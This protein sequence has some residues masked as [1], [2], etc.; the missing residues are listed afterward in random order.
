MRAFGAPAQGLTAI[1][2]SPLQHLGFGWA[3]ADLR[4]AYLL[5]GIQVHQEGLGECVCCLGPERGVR[6]CTAWP[7]RQLALNFIQFTIDAGRCRLGSWG[8]QAWTKHGSCVEEPTFKGLEHEE[9]KESSSPS[10]VT[11]HGQGRAA[12]AASR[13]LRAQRKGVF[14]NQRGFRFKEVAPQS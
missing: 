2:F 3:L 4:V 7:L 8:V 14:R 13:W 6:R 1:W 5:V 9:G 11:L 12:G 10:L